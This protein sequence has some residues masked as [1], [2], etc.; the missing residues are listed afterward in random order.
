MFSTAEL[1]MTFAMTM[2]EGYANGNGTIATVAQMAY[3]TMEAQDEN[4]KSE[5][6]K[7]EAGACASCEMLEAL[8]RAAATK[9][10][11]AV[12]ELNKPMIESTITALL[13][14]ALISLGENCASSTTTTAPA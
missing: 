3:A 10:E 4:I 6:A 14:K 1:G 13:N 12:A 9:I 7:Y 5:A 11:S 8:F 2:V